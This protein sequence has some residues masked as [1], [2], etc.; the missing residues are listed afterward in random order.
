LRGGANR[1]FTG[2]GSGE[3]RPG[4]IRRP[5]VGVDSGRIDPAGFKPAMPTLVTEVASAAEL[6]SLVRRDEYGEIASMA[7][8]LIVDPDAAVVTQWSRSDE[9]RWVEAR[10]DGLG[11]AADPPK[12]G[13]SLRLAAD[14]ESGRFPTDPGPNAHGEIGGASP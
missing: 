2:C 10:I 11:S 14:Y 7:Y 4:R 9:G 8:V 3:T 13:V 12:L 6:D 1:V 5:D